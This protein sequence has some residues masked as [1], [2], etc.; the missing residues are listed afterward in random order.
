MFDMLSPVSGYTYPW[1]GVTCSG[2]G[3]AWCAIQVFPGSYTATVTI[4]DGAGNG[5]DAQGVTATLEYEPG[6]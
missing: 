3:P 2:G 4:R 6:M 5:V 1:S